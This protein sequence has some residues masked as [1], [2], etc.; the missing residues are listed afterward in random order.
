MNI[1]GAAPQ[2]SAATNKSEMAEKP[3]ACYGTLHPSIRL[4][5]QDAEFHNS[6]MK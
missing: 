1:S 4:R 5:T 6:E 3:S 2:A